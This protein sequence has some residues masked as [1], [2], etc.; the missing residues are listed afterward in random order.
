[1]FID[2]NTENKNYIGFTSIGI[3]NQLNSAIKI[4]DT[5]LNHK[6][7][8][9]TILFTFPQKVGLVIFLVGFGFGL[10]IGFIGVFAAII[11][12]LLIPDQLNFQ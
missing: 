6:K 1:M 5:I 2:T 7:I 4:I 12:N 9:Q 3:R 11:L 8:F 10:V